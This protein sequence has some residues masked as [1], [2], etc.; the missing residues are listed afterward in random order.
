MRSATSP[1]RKSKPPARNAKSLERVQ[2]GPD[3]GHHQGEPAAPLR[4]DHAHRPRRGG[5]VTT[6][7]ALLAVTDGLSRSAGDLA[8]LGRADFGVFQAGLADLTASSL[9]DSIVPRIEAIPRIAAAASSRSASCCRRTR[10]ARC[11]LVNAR[12]PPAPRPMRARLL[13]LRTEGRPRPSEPGPA[14]A[15]TANQPAVGV[16][17]TV[18]LF[19]SLGSGIVTSTT[20]SC[21]FAL[22]CLALIPTGSV[23]EREKDPWRRSRRT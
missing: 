4:A 17:L 16:I 5:R 7:V 10:A 12:E 8:K 11:Q 13:R 1:R 9:P 23:I 15:G 19:A 21:V 22:I 2:A 6:V 3:V 18:S 14:P 20:P